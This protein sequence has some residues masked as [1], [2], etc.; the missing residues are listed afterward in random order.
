MQ[1]VSLA[2]R[3]K[4]LSAQKLIT[5]ENLVKATGIIERSKADLAAVTLALSALEGLADPLPTTET[6]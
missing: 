6:T 4:A 3:R 1:T 5:L 2:E